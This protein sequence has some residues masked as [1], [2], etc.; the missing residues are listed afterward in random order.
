MK[1]DCVQ[2]ACS[3]MLA[4]VF[5]VFF[6]KGQWGE[7]YL[8]LVVFVEVNAALLGLPP[9]LRH[10]VIYIG[11]VN[12]FRYELRTA[13]DQW[14]VWGRNFGRVYGVCRA[15]FDKKGEKGEDGADQEDYY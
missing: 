7:M 14:R 5:S 13:F 2:F 6:A 9:V 10:T 11:L 3:I 15:I 4:S 8:V 12:D 1:A